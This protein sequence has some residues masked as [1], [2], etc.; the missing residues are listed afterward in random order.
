MGERVVGSVVL[1]ARSVKRFVLCN[2]CR[3]SIAGRVDCCRTGLLLPIKGRVRTG[4]LSRVINLC[5]PSNALGLTEVSRRG[6][7]PALAAFGG[8][9]AM[10]LGVGFRRSCEFI[11][12]Y[13]AI[14]LV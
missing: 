3:F 4:M 6:A 1:G 12:L 9:S 13:P 11:M 7:S 5:G 10:P 14:F 2:C 8:A